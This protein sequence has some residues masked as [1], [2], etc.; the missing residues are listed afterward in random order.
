MSWSGRLKADPVGEIA[1][2]SDMRWP[3]LLI[4][5]LSC[6][7]VVIAHN[8]FQVWLYMKPCEQCVYIRF[9]FLV[10]ALGAL[11]TVINPKNLI[12]K[13]VGLVVSV[14][15]AV[16]GLMCSFKL[17]SIHH[18]IHGDDMEAVFGMQGCSL[19]PKYPFGLALE[20][21]APDW[22]LPTGD[23]GYDTAVVPD[24]TVLSSAQQFLINMYNSADSWYLIPAW[25]FMSMA[26]C[27][28][29]AFGVALVMVVVL[30]GASFWKRF[31][32]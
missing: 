15:G 32:A 22:F 17:S 25:K 27:C 4:I 6:A 30:T 21:W 2:W 16:Y 11:I 31:K 10:V 5:F 9:G 18:A 8:V 28:I 13:L 12:L 26:Q 23:C 19:E 29:L 1:R 20:K 7:L 3:W 24:G 14:Y